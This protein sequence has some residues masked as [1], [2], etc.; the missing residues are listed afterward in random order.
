MKFYFTDPD[1]EDHGP[2]NSQYEAHMAARAHANEHGVIDA[3]FTNLGPKCE[4]H[5]KWRHLKVK[6]KRWFLGS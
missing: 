4:W 2:F 3:V 1:G 5:A 6:L